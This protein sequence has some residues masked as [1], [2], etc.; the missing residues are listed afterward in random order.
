MCLQELQQLA[1]ETSSYKDIPEA[2]MDD[3]I[4]CLG[5]KQLMERKGIWLYPIAHVRDVKAMATHMAGEVHLVREVH[6]WQ[7][8][9]T[10][11]CK[12]QDGLYGCHGP[13][14]SL[15]SQSAD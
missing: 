3:T 5:E 15:P 14:G 1:K 8:E 6:G 10:V 12:L 11:Y 7:V 13:Q 9:L 2:E 4:H